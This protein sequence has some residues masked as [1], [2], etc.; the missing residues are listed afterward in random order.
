[1]RLV[2]NGSVVVLN[3]LTYQFP[4]GNNRWDANW[5]V[6]A[7]TATSPGGSWSFRDAALTT[8]EAKHVSRWLRSVAQGT[9]D[10][11]SP[12]DEGFLSPTLTFTEPNLAFSVAGRTQ[13]SVELRVHLSH[14]FAPT[15]LDI[16][17]RMNM[18]QFFVTLAMQPSDLV[19]AA[20]VWDEDWRAFPERP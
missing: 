10:V 16:D 15:W 14:E 7:G 3:P 11:V 17:E 20:G 2:G 8:F 19:E 1:M 5:V 9:V 13:D 4:S 18:W 6:I 12:D